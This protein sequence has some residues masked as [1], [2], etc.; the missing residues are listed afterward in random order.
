M[1]AVKIPAAQPQTFFCRWDVATKHQ[2]EEQ[3]SVPLYL[4]GNGDACPEANGQ[5]LVDF[6]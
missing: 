1:G 4:H 2:L 5:S 6:D 3:P